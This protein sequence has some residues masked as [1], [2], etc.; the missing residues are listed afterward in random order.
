[1]VLACAVALILF[2]SAIVG[3][4]VARIRSLFD[5]GREVEDSVRKVTYFGVE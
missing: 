1:M 3:L 5:G 4:R 2:L